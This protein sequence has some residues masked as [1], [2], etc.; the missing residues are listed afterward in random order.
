VSIPPDNRWKSFNQIVDVALRVDT[1]SPWLP[2]PAGL[3][4]DGLDVVLAERS[5]F[6]E[7]DVFIGRKVARAA[8][9]TT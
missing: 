8:K 6:I 9:I 4:G 5:I 2:R 1:P 3:L 7:M